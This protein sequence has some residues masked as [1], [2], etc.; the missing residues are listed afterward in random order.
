[1]A[2]I[3][4]REHLTHCGHL[5]WKG[6]NK[7]NRSKHGKMMVNKRWE[8]HGT[9]KEVEGIIKSGMTT[10]QFI[11]KKRVSELPSNYEKSRVSKLVRG[12][13]ENTS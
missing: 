8:N 13:H 12:L 7:R 2:E 6:V 1:M 10:G 11:W 9:E 3:T 5:R 4:L